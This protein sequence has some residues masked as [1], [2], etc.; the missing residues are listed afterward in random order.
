MSKSSTRL[1]GNGDYLAV[2]GEDKQYWL[3]KCRQ[4]VYEEKTKTF[5]VQWL[6]KEASMYKYPVKTTHRKSPDRSNID[7]CMIYKYIYLLRKEI[8][9]IIIFNF[10]E[11]IYAISFVFSFF[12]RKNTSIICRKTGGEFPLM[13]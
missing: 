7:V 12:C 3:C 9:I 13:L 5:W 4:H 2:V 8:W 6:E 10:E 11:L 1:F